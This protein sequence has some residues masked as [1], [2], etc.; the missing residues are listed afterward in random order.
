[1]HKTL[2]SYACYHTL[3]ANLSFHIILSYNM[4]IYYLGIIMHNYN[5]ISK[6]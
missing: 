5:K 6:S 3:S 4:K 1:M 2:H